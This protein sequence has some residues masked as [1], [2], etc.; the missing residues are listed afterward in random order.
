MFGGRLADLLGRK[1]TILTGLVGLA[2]VSARWGAVRVR[3]HV[4]GGQDGMTPYCEWAAQVS[5]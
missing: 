3:V 2:G 4:I 5:D 1:V